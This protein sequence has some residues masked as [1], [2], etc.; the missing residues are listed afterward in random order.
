MLLN[1]ADFG[2]GT[3][4]KVSTCFQDKLKLNDCQTDFLENVSQTFLITNTSYYRFKSSS[5][6]SGLI[7]N[8]S[9]GMHCNA[10]VSVQVLAS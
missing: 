8:M 6:C 9:E 7:A 1:F 3:F 2:D 5:M 10:K 4:K